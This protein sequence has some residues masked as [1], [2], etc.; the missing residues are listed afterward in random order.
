VIYTTRLR[1]LEVY[2]LAKR[3]RLLEQTNAETSP[4]KDGLRGP[5]RVFGRP[6]CL[7]ASKAHRSS[8]WLVGYSLDCIYTPYS[9]LKDKSNVY[10]ESRT[11]VTKSPSCSWKQVG[12]TTGAFP[13]AIDLQKHI[14]WFIGPDPTRFHKEF[15]VW[16]LRQV[17]EP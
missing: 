11:T 17:R 16:S 12:P 4:R 10:L 8:P 2:G 9:T 13:K 6:N 14:P 7:K 5:P 1:R 15:Q 3:N